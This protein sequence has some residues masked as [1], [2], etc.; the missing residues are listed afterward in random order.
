MPTTEEERNTM[1]QARAA[2]EGEG[3]RKLYGKNFDEC[4]SMQRVTVGG[5]LGGGRIQ[6]MAGKTENAAEGTN[7][8]ER[9]E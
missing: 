7:T 3:E 2:R 8:G 9:N 5:H 4:D 6:E 1:A